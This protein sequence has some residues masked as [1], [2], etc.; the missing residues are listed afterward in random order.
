M[1]FGDRLSDV[2]NGP[3]HTLN[4]KLPDPLDMNGYFD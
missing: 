2:E 1:N 3:K 4:V